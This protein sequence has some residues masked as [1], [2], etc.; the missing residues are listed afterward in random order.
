MQISKTKVQKATHFNDLNVS[1]ILMKKFI[2][3]N[4]GREYNFTAIKDTLFLFNFTK[5]R[6]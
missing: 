4:H 5:W 6:F 2:E 1:F 3:I